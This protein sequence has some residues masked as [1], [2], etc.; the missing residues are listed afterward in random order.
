VS[1]PP[2]EPPPASPSFAVVGAGI[3]GLCTA[4]ALLES[5][6]EV[7]VYELGSPGCGQSAGES[8]IFRH[9]HDDPRLVAFTAEGRAIWS[10]WEGELGTELVSRDGVVAIGDPVPGR[11]EKLERAGVEVVT[12]DQEGI[13]EQLPI[14]AGY[15]GPAMFDPGGGAIRVRAAVEALAGRLGERIRAEEVISL[16]PD[17]EGVEIRTPNER[18]SFEAAIVCAGR[19]TPRLARTMGLTLPVAHS[20]HVRVTFALRGAAPERLACFQDG[21]GEYGETGVYAAPLPGNA[22]YAVGVAEETAADEGGSLSD[23]DE[24]AELERRAVAYVERAFPG[25][26]PDPVGLLHAPVTTVPWGDDGLAAW[27]H[28]GCHF[29]AGHNLFKQ[30]PRLGRALAAA[31][32]A[33]GPAEPLLRPESRLGEPEDDD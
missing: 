20:A 19:Q 28:R 6:A 1:G 32:I 17:G 3:V 15:D 21:S 14:F 13:A 4:Y 7:R 22:R 30:A 31:A 18:A 8:R 2:A 9:A 23:P 24:L 16:R 27:E 5:G 12:I 33:G 26:D 11:Q 29:A 10:E 25:L